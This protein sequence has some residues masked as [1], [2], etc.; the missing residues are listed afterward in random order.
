MSLISPIRTLIGGCACIEMFLR[1]PISALRFFFFFFCSKLEMLQRDF[2]L[3]PNLPMF[4][5]GALTVL[6]VPLTVS[7]G[8]GVLVRDGMTVVGCEAGGWGQPHLKWR[9]ANV[10]K[11]IS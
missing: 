6:T 5:S 3:K 4:R 9:V 8:E 10:G 11:V 2:T 7:T 1:H